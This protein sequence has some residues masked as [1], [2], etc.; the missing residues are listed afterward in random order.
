MI[1]STVERATCDDAPYST[2]SVSR[3]YVM[4]RSYLTRISVPCNTCSV[5]ILRRPTEV[6]ERNYCSVECRQAVVARFASERCGSKHPRWNGG[7]L[8]YRGP[9]WNTQKTATLERDS[10]QCQHC[11][12]IG[13]DVHHKIPFRLFD[14]YRQANDLSNL[15]T[16]CKRCHGLADAAFW[17]AQDAP[18]VTQAAIYPNVNCKKC[19]VVFDGRQGVTSSRGVMR[20]CANCRNIRLCKHC[21]QPFDVTTRRRSSASLCSKS[22]QYAFMQGKPPT[23]QLQ[24]RNL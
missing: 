17:F 3:L 9:N 13:T 12:A 11:P 2:T 18:L 23:Y 24:R 19:G 21:H 5:V 7:R 1:Y 15:I 4:G 6:G 20:L 22:C 16:L 14:D 10:R 8:T